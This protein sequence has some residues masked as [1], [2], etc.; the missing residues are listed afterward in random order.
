[1][2]DFL[3]LG[4]ITFA[5]IWIGSQI[6]MHVLATRIRKAGP[7]RLMDYIGDVEWLGNRLQA[8]AALLVVIF[9][10]LLVLED[11]F[12]FGSLWII[13]GL[14]GFIVVMGIASGYLVPQTR[15]IRELATAH[16]VE[17]PDVQAKIK[18]VL[19]VSS[20]ESVLMIAIVLDMVAKP[21][22]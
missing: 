11:G 20:L 10:V 3:L 17:A 18:S 2:R 9:G 22:L 8:P 16:G 21:G 19:R 6:G 12:S 7:D 1:M 14:L 5:M 15:Q 4:H 13:L